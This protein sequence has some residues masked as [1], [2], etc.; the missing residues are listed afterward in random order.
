MNSDQNSKRGNA[1][2][3]MW[4]GGVLAAAIIVGFIFSA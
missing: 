4:A 3:L 2:L 1:V